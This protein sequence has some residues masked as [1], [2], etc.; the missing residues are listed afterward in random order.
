[1]NPINCRPNIVFHNDI[2][3]ASE[4][5]N[6]PAAVKPNDT[7][8]ASDQICINP[9]HY[10]LTVEAMNRFNKHQQHPAATHQKKAAPSPAHAKKSQNQR[11]SKE[12]SGSR[13]KAKEE[14]SIDFEDDGIDYIKMWDEKAVAGSKSAEGPAA[15][16]SFDVETMISEI[17]FLDIRKAAIG[18]KYADEVRYMCDVDEKLKSALKDKMKRQILSGEYLNKKTKR[19][20]SSSTGHGRP[21]V[22]A[23]DN[24]IEVNFVKPAQPPPP[25]K[26]Q[27]VSATKQ[28]PTVSNAAGGGLPTQNADEDAAIQDILDDIRGSFERQFDRD[29]EELT[30]S[31]EASG[32]GGQ[33]GGRQDGGGGGDHDR[34]VSSAA[35]PA[36]SELPFPMDQAFPLGLENIQP[37]QQSAPQQQMQQQQQPFQPSLFPQQQQLEEMPCI[38]DAFTVDDDASGDGA[39]FLNAGSISQEE[40]RGLDNLF[41]SEQMGA[42]PS[43]VPD[44]G[45]SQQD[46]FLPQQ[47]QQ[48]NSNQPFMS[49]APTQQQQQQHY[50][51]F[52]FDQQNL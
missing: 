8:D 25:H 9:Y 4:H 30:T 12:S 32:D 51:N 33:V 36:T 44:L 37:M 42:G 17:N 40:W 15:L 1:M 11:S 21:A 45:S 19:T 47:P 18:T 27:L 48:Y 23:A 26:V 5:C 10:V 24:K 31:D 50:S 6:Y 38:V 52:N 7:V 16:S 20:P 49:Q 2:R 13:S 34:P 14:R 39:N 22:E 3:C 28:A 46:L 35:A 29:F 41:S 43:G